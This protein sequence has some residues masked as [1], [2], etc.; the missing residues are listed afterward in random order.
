MRTREIKK[1]EIENAI[2]AVIFLAMM[3]GFYVWLRFFATFPAREC[4]VIN[5]EPVKGTEYYEV[6][7]EDADGEVWSY[8]ADNYTENGVI[9]VLFDGDKIVDVK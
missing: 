8:F 6:T 3:I 4:T 1:R 9:N 2:S 7:V 5:C